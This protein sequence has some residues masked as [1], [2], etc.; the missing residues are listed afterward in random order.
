[1]G[2]LLAVVIAADLAVLAAVLTVQWRRHRAVLSPVTAD[3][4]EMFL[5]PRPAGLR[6]RERRLLTVEI[7]DPNEVAAG[8]GR[9]LGLVGALAP[10]LVRRVVY[11]RTRTTLLQE[12]AAQ[13]VRADVRIHTLGPATPQQARTDT[14]G[15]AVVIE[16]AVVDAP[17]P[18]DL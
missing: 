9:A 7:L 5:A 6:G 3:P 4:G 13:G 2:V 16:A 14:S 12:L 10:G 11:D 18:L 8:R 17:P 1:V 15:P